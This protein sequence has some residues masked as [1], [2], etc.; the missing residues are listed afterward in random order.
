MP[1]LEWHIYE[2]GYCMHPECA[3]RQGAPFKPARYPALAF[4]LRHPQLGWILF[5]TGY[6]KHFL[7]ATRRLP[8]RLYR[9]VTPV[10]LDAQQTLCEQLRRDGIAPADIAAVVLSHF[11]GDHIAGVCDFPQARLICAREAWDDLQARG[12]IDALRHGLL[13]KLLP[14][15]FLARVEWI[16]EK[17]L[18]GLPATFAAF[19]GG[20]DLLGDGSLVAIALPGHAR[21]HY[22]VVFDAVD[23]QRVFLVADAAWSSQA[24]RADTPPPALITGLLGDTRVYRQTL[25]QLHALAKAEP[26]LRLLPSHC[27]PWRQA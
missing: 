7:D 6:A 17:P 23:G 5:D 21:G 16:E 12:R 19:G 4:L 2:A 9:T 8:E 24:I 3:T 14:D 18:H 27:D 26:G 11:H 20:Y 25:S 13:P 10:H 15:D 1:P 22:G